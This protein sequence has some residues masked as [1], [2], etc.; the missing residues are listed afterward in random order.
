MAHMNKNSR[1]E[2]EDKFI[3][4]NV[5]LCAQAPKYK[6]KRTLITA[7]LKRPEGFCCMG[8]EMW[9]QQSTV[10][11]RAFSIVHA[12]AEGTAPMLSVSQAWLGYFP[13]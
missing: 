2:L 1:P 13:S 7:L 9:S 10:S 11:L 6:Q 12:G 5:K 8:Q 4:R 3:I